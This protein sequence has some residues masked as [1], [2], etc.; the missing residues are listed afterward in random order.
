MSGW[1]SGALFRFRPVFAFLGIAG[2]TT[3]SSFMVAVTALKRAERL[4]DMAHCLVGLAR[5]DVRSPLRTTDLRVSGI[6]AVMTFGIWLYTKLNQQLKGNRFFAL[7]FH[8]EERRRRGFNLRRLGKRAR[9]RLTGFAG[10]RMHKIV[11]RV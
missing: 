11:P 5:L 6:V 3:R 7:Q 8:F 2:S 4:E 9:C 10:R 1:G